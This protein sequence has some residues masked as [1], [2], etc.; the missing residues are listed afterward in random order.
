MPNLAA[1]KTTF[2]YGGSPI[3]EKTGA[4]ENYAARKTALPED[5]HHFLFVLAVNCF[6]QAV[7]YEFCKP[8]YLYIS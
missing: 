7:G 2:I 3:E 8:I 4:P 1:V 5:V 6:R